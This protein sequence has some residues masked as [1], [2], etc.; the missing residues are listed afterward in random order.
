MR[1][2]AFLPK[3]WSETVRSSVL[4][5]I[6]CAAAA[7]TTAW[8][9]SASS[10]SDRIRGTAEADRIRA[11]LALIREELDLHSGRGRHLRQGLFA[12][13]EL[14]APVGVRPGAVGLNRHERGHR[15]RL[16]RR[17][18]ARER[19]DL[20]IHVDRQVIDDD[21]LVLEHLIV[22]HA[23]VGQTRAPAVDVVAVGRAVA[24]EPQEV[25]LEDGFPESLRVGA[26]VGRR[27]GGQR[28]RD[29]LG[30]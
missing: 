2:R 13:Q 12:R 16:R 5:A 3:N 24:V 9:R 11:E 7:M 1:A 6:S 23:V 29:D 26:R 21:E 22:C 15:Q 10:Q 28:V 17:F 8:S 4:H 20:T 27:V 25:L 30:P 19:V 18:A 14:I